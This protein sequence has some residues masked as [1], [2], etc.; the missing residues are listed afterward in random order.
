MDPLLNHSIN[1]IHSLSWLFTL[2]HIVSPVFQLIMISKQTYIYETISVSRIFFK[3]IQ[4]F[5]KTLEMGHLYWK[6]ISNLPF[7]RIF[8]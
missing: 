8:Y 6:F 1:D 7:R 2:K 4:L 3:K 5:Q